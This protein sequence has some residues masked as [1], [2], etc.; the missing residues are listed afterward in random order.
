MKLVSWRSKRIRWL[1]QAS[2]ASGSAVIL[3][4]VNRSAQP[5][6]PHARSRFED[7][8]AVRPLRF[9]GPS[10]KTILPPFICDMTADRENTADLIGNQATAR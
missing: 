2:F 6:H 9:P 5:H 4:A 8:G 7:A 1:A 3:I 10:G